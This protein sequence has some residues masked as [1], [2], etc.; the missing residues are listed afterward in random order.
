M[1]TPKI[2]G[3]SSGKPDKKFKKWGLQ[4]LHFPDQKCNYDV[5]INYDVIVNGD[6]TINRQLGT[7]E[8]PVYVQWQ[9]WTNLSMYLTNG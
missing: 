2:W 8:C 1:C 5:I 9:C 7:S 3:F 4:K 6:V